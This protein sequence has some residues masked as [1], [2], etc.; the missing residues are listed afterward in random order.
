MRRNSYLFFTIL[1]FIETNT[2]IAQDSCDCF[3]FSNSILIEYVDCNHFVLSKALKMNNSNSLDSIIFRKKL[4]DTFY[5]MDS[6]YYYNYND[7]LI[8]IFSFKSAEIDTIN[9]FSPY[10]D[11]KYFNDSVYVIAHQYRLLHVIENY[12]EYELF[13]GYGML[14]ENSCLSFKCLS[15]LLSSDLHFGSVFSGVILYG[16]WFGSKMELISMHEIRR[17][18]F[19]TCKNIMKVEPTR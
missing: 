15:Q 2:V 9:V 1:F 7:S 13:Y 14:P 10:F 4:I 3:I 8:R 19:G 18:Y 5:I 16:H 11:V 12:F 17:S 6:S